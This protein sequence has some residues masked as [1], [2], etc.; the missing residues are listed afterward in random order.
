LYQRQP[1][2]AI[3]MKIATNNLLK[4]FNSFVIATSASLL[5]LAVHAEGAVRVLDCK[6]M[7]RCDAAGSCEARSEAIEFR[8]EPQALADDG[9]GQ[10]LLRYRDV[11]V[12]MQ[13]LGE[14]GPFVWSVG[15]VRYT[16]LVS[17]ETQLLLHALELAAAP[18]TTIDFLECSVRQ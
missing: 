3:D 4:Q 5:S 10:Y 15:S 7:Q 9:S 8:L 1:T 17:S 6:T 13:A 12:P 2:A 11:E 16:L 18:A 14:A